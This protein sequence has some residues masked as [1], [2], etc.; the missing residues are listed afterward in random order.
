MTY[1]SLAYL[2]AFLPVV[3]AL[4]ILLPRG[5]RRY[6]LL[7]ASYLFYLLFSPKL[8]VYLLASTAIIYFSGRWMEKYAA[9]PAAVKKRRA[10]F[11]CAVILQLGTLLFLK[12]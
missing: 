3:L 5:L 11:W 1:T 9:V 10:I 4:Y 2:L 6:L 12:F 8:I 7:A